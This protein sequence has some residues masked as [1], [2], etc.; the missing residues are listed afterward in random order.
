[1]DVPSKTRP[2]S[3][4]RSTALSYALHDTRF[5]SWVEDADVS[6]AIGRIDQQFRGL[7]IA[8]AAREDVPA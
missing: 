4:P 2:T 7:E 3:A 1:V 6:T 5:D 8:A